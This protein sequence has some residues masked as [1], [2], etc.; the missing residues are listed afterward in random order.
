MIPYH[1]MTLADVFTETQEIFESD[2]PE[3]LKLL[4]STI[5]L[6]E[7]VPVSFR[8]H[9][10]ASTG[11]PREYSL[12]SLLW[13]LII[14]RIFSIP[15]DSLLLT[16]LE[17]SRDLREFCGFTKVPDASKI[18][19]F[20]QEFINDLQMFFVSLV[21]LTEPILQE[22]DA[23]KA[24]MSVFDTTGLEAYVTENNPKYAN[25]K[26]RQLKAWAKAAYGSMPTH[27]SSDAEIKQQY[28]NGHFCYAYKAGVLTNG[29][30]IIRAIEFYDKD[31]FAFHP[32]IERYKKTDAPDEDKSVGDARL[33]LPLLK[34]FFRKHPLINPKTFLGDAAFDSIEIYKALLSGDTFGCCPDGT[35]RIFEKACIPLRS[36]LKLTD[37]DYTINEN[38]IPCCPHDPDL[39][40]KPEG[41]TSHL[42]CGL[43]TFKFVCPKMKWET[44]EDGKSHRVCH[45]EDPCTVSACG[46]MVYLYPEKDLR[47]CPGVIR[48]TE[49]WESTYKIR[50]SVE[51]SINHIKDSFCL[52]DRKTQNAKTLH[53]DLLLA[54]ITQLIT[55]VVA[56]RIHKPE[57][58][59]S[60]KRLIA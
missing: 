25:Q 9:F 34:D 36:A 30:G 11:R 42:R 32:E 23:E 52:G 45:C 46:R 17:Y 16:F 39:P 33:L 56:D 58:F 44:G 40:M 29:L 21:D 48:G 10:Y 4:E 22:I 51:R 60:L 5:D 26:I 55:V 20:K 19:R 8:N 7:I 35:P 41:N 49:E 27:A 38:G 59:R 6:C 12:T 18:T 37:P 57:Y 31:Y 13:A 50:T 43:K 53:A 47:R 2:K 24:S 14:Q 28:L 54:G 15:T 3:F 1:Q